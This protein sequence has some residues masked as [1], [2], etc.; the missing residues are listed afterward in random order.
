MYHHRPTFWRYTTVSALLPLVSFWPVVFSPVTKQSAAAHSK[1]PVAA[2]AVAHAQYLPL[3]MVSSINV[4][5]TIRLTVT[6]YSSTVDQT[7][8]DPFTTASGAQV[9]D[10]IIAHNTLPFGTRVRLPEAFG[11]KI[12]V[13]MD[14]LHPRKGSYI[15]DIW[16]PSREEAK[17]W[18]AKILKMEILDS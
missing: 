12:F 3:P 4:S 14:R 6:A 9:R 7:D 8:G 5:K 15:A 13:V 2:V 18:G 1:K 11:E 17:T 16:M 10:G